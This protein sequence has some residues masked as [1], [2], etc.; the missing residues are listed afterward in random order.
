MWFNRLA[1]DEK[2]PAGERT[3]VT[4]AWQDEKGTGWLADPLWLDLC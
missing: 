4:G 1:G 2:L 3:A